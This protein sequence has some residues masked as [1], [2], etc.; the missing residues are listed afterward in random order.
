M[1]KI[2][3][4]LALIAGAVTSVQAAESCAS[5]RTALEKEIAIAQ[6]YGNAYK[7]AGLKKALAEVNAHCTNESVLADARKD[8]SKLEKKLAEKRSDVSEVQADL[9]EAQRKGDAKKIA[10]YQS[11]LAEKRADLNEI[12]QKLNQARAELAQRQK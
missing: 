8:V 12:Q 7:V 5:K 9:A 11:K 6:Q 2:M 4:A 10:K 3:M 1:K